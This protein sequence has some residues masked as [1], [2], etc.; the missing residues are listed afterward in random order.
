MSDTNDIAIESRGRLGLITLDRPDA[1]NALTLPM[2]RE[3][4]QG[5][6]RFASDRGIQSVAVRGAGGR[7]FCAGG[8]IQ[9]IYR[10]GTDGHPEE[11]LTFWA[12]EYDLNRLIKRYRKPYIALIDG[13]VMGGGVGVSIHGSHRVAGE[14][15]QMA[16]PEV[17]IGFFPDVGATFALPRLPWRSGYWLGLT[18]ARI[19]RGAAL[20]LGIATHSVAGG[21]FEAIIEALAAGEEPDAVLAR[22][23]VPAGEGPELAH[24]DLIASCFAGATVES[25]LEALHRAA[26]AGSDFARDAASAIETKS[27][28][29]LKVTLAALE[30]GL[31]LEF[32]EAMRLEYRICARIIRGH[33]LYEGIRAQ[34]IDKD[35]KPRWQPAELRLVS[36][37]AV[38]SH[39]APLGDDELVFREGPA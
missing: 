27:P 6:D 38:E 22:E 24:Q 16:M 12:E 18:G 30:R 28:T 8:D 9:T 3:M 17:G 19:G 37:D 13:I 10:Q 21:R 5:L 25:I 4:R 31:E 15:F 35:R 14:R 7:A 20:G 33:D 29:S 32:E 11:A 1:L 2:V 34:V 39:F 26:A 36:P 23:A